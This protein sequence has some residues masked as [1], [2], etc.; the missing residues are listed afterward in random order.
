MKKSAKKERLQSRWW[1]HHLPL[2]I[3]S[4]ASLLAINSFMESD[5]APYR[6]SMA[7][8]YVSLALLVITIILGPLK[9]LTGKRYPK[10][11]DIR[12]DFGIWSALIAIAHVVV[13]LQVHMGNPLLYFFMQDSYPQELVLRSD[14]FGFA[15]YT[16]VVATLIVVFL[17]ALSNDFSLKKF[18]GRRWKSLQRWSYGLFAF[19]IVHGIAYQLIENRSFLFV[20]I[21]AILIIGAVIMQMIGIFQWKK[22]HKY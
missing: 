2:A 16:G 8:G 22:K 17:L 21:F 14:L 15:N 6:W 13:G 12:R 10:S 5:H 19:V 9:I 11:T 4:I 18:G 1:K 3:A 7:T 20:W